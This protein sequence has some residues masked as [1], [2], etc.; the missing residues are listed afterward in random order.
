MSDETRKLL[1]EI[2]GFL[3][4]VRDGLVPEEQARRESAALIDKIGDSIE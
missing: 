4:L 1:I 2:A 3:R